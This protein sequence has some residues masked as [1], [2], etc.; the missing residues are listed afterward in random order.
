M[1]FKSYTYDAVPYSNYQK[2]I[3]YVREASKLDMLI[4]SVTISEE[5]IIKEVLRKGSYKLK[6]TVVVTPANLRASKT[7]NKV[8]TKRRHTRGSIVFKSHMLARVVSASGNILK[9]F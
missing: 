6:F 4:G 1:K 5:Y 2:F 3:F 9:K 8:S 7:R